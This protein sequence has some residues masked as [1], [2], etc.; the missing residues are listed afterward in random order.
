MSNQHE[1]AFINFGNALTNYHAVEMQS[2]ANKAKADASE[3]SDPQDKL[4]IVQQAEIDVN[5]LNGRIFAFI[6][7]NKM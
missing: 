1:Q 7:K 5:Q 4:D 2:I 3:A 6:G